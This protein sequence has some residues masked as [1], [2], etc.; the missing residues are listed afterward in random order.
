MRIKN[1]DFPQPLLE[2]RQNGKL[3]IFA[4]AGVSIPPPSNYP[5]FDGLAERVAGGSLSR[6]KDERVDHFLG[7]LKDQGVAVH[8]IVHRML[9]DEQSHPNQLHR[10]LLNLFDGPAKIRLVT[11]NFDMH[12]N[13]SLTAVFRTE[14]ET[15]TYT[16]PALPLGSS[17]SGIV[18]LHGNVAKPADRLILTDSDF[19][20]A[21]L[22]DGWAT[23]FL[24]QLFQHNIILFV[25]YSHND[26]VVDYVARGLTPESR[27]PRRY[28]LTLGGN[29]AH[30]K[31]LGITPIVYPVVN[32]LDRHVVLSQAIEGG[33]N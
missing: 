10:A 12:F 29:E 23:R 2:A 17:F 5:D 3:V 19:G 8:A 6:E 14:A 31:R 9:S 11:T 4:G 27:S 20:S 30:W 21:Y 26:T 33:A 32:D 7:R 25:G 13:S 1:V 15:E 24:Q 18:Y 16:A 28:A 22:A